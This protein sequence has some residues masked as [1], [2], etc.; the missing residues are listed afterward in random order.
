ML[1]GFLFWI[2][3]LVLVLYL[4]SFFFL[5][6]SNW[7]V[8]VSITINSLPTVND[9]CL[10]VAVRWMSLALAD[11]KS[12]LVQ[13]MSRCHQATCHYMSQ[14]W[15][16]SMWPYASGVILCMRPAN[17][18]RRYNV[19]S[20]LIGLAHTQNEPWK[21]LVSMISQNCSMLWNLN[22]DGLVQD[23]KTSKMRMSS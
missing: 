5:N 8:L 20:S 17:E 12:T 2:W 7:L 9:N 13:V 23:F 22:I 19:T 1:L 21:D 10:E 6:I 3:I 4:N 18:R 16:R 14:C 15:P 11:D